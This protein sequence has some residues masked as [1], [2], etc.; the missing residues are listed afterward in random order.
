MH[1][2]NAE[3]LST[4]TDDLDTP[5]T[6]NLVAT[7]V[8]NSDHAQGTW[9]MQGPECGAIWSETTAIRLADCHGTFTNCYGTD[10][11]NQASGP[12]WRYG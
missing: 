8:I 10:L 9:I 11:T 12:G 3:S 5:S 6:R 1:I 7:T 2:I 4:L